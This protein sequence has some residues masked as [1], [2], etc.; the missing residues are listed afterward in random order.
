MFYI[1]VYQPEIK[2]NI[3]WYNDAVINYCNHSVIKALCDVFIYLSQQYNY[4]DIVYR[5]LY[6]FS[7]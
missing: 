6:N 5:F 7:T 2:I 4:T 3:A 1:C